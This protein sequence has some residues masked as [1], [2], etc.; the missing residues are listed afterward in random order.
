MIT[1]Q[2][3]DAPHC[4]EV[5]SP[6][7]CLFLALCG[8][9][10]WKCN[11]PQHLRFSL[12]SRFAMRYTGKLKANLIAN[13]KRKISG[14]GNVEVMDDAAPCRGM[15]AHSEVDMCFLRPCHQAPDTAPR[16]GQSNPSHAAGNLQQTHLLHS[17]S[18][19]H[20]CKS[21]HS[22]MIQNCNVSSASS[23]VVRH[24]H[25]VRGYLFVQ[26]PGPKN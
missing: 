13:K 6:V 10:A 25:H 19:I 11:T 17:P 20:E 22:H 23:I 9:L 15:T 5:H 21:F 18:L 12:E 3:V 1:V 26:R 2:V 8:L 14:N 4:T 24:L 16:P 7:T